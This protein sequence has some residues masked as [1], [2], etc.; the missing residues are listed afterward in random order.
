MRSDAPQCVDS[1]G[2]VLVHIGGGSRDNNFSRPMCVLFRIN[3]LLASSL[4]LVMPLRKNCI[5][6]QSNR[7][8]YMP[9]LSCTSRH[10]PHTC[11]HLA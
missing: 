4:E 5:V 3:D 6:E 11:P 8:Y 10:F 7:I 2:L 1:R 9:K